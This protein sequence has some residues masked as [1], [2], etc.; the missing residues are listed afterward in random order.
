IF[1]AVGLGPTRRLDVPGEDRP[2]VI[3]ALAFI[4]QVKSRKWQSIPLGRNVAVIGAGNTAIDA[5][6]QAK[7]LGAEKV[8][9]IYRRGESDAPAYAYELQLAK[10]DGVE[11]IWHTTVEAIEGAEHIEALY[12]KNAD[13]EVSRIPCD[14]LIKAI[15]QT[16]MSTFFT[17]VCGVAVDDAGRVT[18][19]DSMQTSVPGVF[20]GGDCVNGGAEAVDAAQM[21]KIA[22]AAIH[23]QLFGEEIKFAGISV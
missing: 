5:A 12:L 2:G 13:G 20:A 11:F 16:K 8:T 1:I 10:T 23:R 14:M 4:E 9:L 6:T 19:D 15:G 18:V 17:D 22:A 21:G 3:D 7:R